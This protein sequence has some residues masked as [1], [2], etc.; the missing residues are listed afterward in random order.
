MS[1]GDIWVGRSVMDSDNGREVVLSAPRESR[2][3]RAGAGPGGVACNGAALAGSLE[4]G[5]CACSIVCKG[6]RPVPSTPE[7]PLVLLTAEEALSIELRLD[8]RPC[9]ADRTLPTAAA[10]PAPNERFL[11]SIPSLGGNIEIVFGRSTGVA[12]VGGRIIWL[13]PFLYD[14]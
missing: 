13:T 10:A 8:V 14:K 3:S 5:L 2:P 4:T 6:V 1:V 11:P 12:L 7:A 9:L